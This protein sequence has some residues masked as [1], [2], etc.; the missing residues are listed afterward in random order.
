[1]RRLVSAGNSHAA[2]HSETAAV[3]AIQL[4]SSLRRTLLPWAK[5]RRGQSAASGGPE[6]DFVI[7]GNRCV[8]F[9]EVKWLATEGRGQGV[10]QDKGQMQLRREFL[11]K[12]G[13]RV[14]GERGFS[15]LGMSRGEPLERE[16]PPDAEGVVTRTDPNS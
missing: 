6:L 7:D 15:V 5:S 14:Y 12:Y 16:T 8:V 9:G 2:R 3:G 11:G 10:M 4:Y 1:M 13:R